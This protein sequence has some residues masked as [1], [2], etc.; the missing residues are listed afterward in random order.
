MRHRRGIVFVLAG[1]ALALAA[2][3]SAHVTK[4]SG[5]LRLSIGWGDEPPVAGSKNIVQVEVSDASG[6]PVA[7]PPGALDVQVSFGGAHVT[8]PLSPGERPGELR[9]PIVPTRPGSY[10]FH[11]TGTLRGHGVD[12]GAACSEATFE[13][14]VP[15]SDLE[16]PVKD[17]SAGELPQRLSR[18]SA[19]AEHAADTAD[20]ARRVAI[21]AIAIAI[22]AIAVA[23][24]LGLR[25]RRKRA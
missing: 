25:S 10:A 17:P 22:A 21:A 15:V 14:V 13:C 12:V 1:L 24:A 16:F 7:V 8:L 11:V 4:A 6:A 3:A 20:A 5:Q 18:E 2:P 23:L 19:R 9:A